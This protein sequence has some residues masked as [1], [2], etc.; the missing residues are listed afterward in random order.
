ME[1]SVCFPS[2]P[3]GNNQH[4]NH[5]RRPRKWPPTT[6]YEVQFWCIRV[7]LIGDNAQSK[8]VCFSLAMSRSKALKMLRWCSND[9]DESCLAIRAF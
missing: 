1:E 6:A 9:G 4:H 3:E 7:G 8:Q 5:G 2:L